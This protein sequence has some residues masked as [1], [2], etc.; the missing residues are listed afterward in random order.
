MSVSIVAVPMILW[1]IPSLP[2]FVASGLIGAAGVG[3]GIMESRN[4]KENYELSQNAISSFFNN[5]ISADFYTNLETAE[6]V[7]SVINNAG[8]EIIMNRPNEF[9]TIIDSFGNNAIWRNINGKWVVTITSIV[10]MARNEFNRMTMDYMKLITNNFKDNVFTKNGEGKL[11]E[12]KYETVF[13]DKNILLK[14]LEEHGAQNIKIDG[15]G[16]SCIIDKVKFEFEKEEDKPYTV[17]A[18]YDGNKEDLVNYMSDINSEY[19]ENVQEQTY[20]TIKQRVEEQNLQI[21]NEEI[22]EDN[23]IL[24]TINLD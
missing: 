16:V 9:T 12:Y 19:C 14:T 21:E 13:Q 20:E 2:V 6:E 17:I 3:L 18:S 22:L 11:P 10:P 8:F 4:N 24:L 7:T 1:A 23:S 5:N 15:N